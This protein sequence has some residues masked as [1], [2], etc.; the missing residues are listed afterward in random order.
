MVLACDGIWDCMTNQ[1]V[2][3]FVR[4][5][6]KQKKS[7][8]EICEELM[9]ECLADHS[10]IGGVGC[11]NMTVIIV[12]LLQGKTSDQWFE[13]IG[14]KVPNRPVVRKEKDVLKP[15]DRTEEPEA[16]KQRQQGDIEEKL[17]GIIQETSKLRE[18]STPK[19]EEQI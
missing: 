6:I 17:D 7:L 3:D 14:E 5:G 8:K 11:D 19:G 13:H 4:D 1:Q 15:S 9:D 10:D 16:K 2:V 12:A 18:A